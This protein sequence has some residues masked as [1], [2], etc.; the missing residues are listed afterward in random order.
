MC[1]VLYCRCCCIVRFWSLYM[2]WIFWTEHVALLYCIAITSYWKSHTVRSFLAHQS[3]DRYTKCTEHLYTLTLGNAA[4]LYRSGMSN[5]CDMCIIKK[6]KKLKL[7][8]CI[9]NLNRILK[10]IYNFLH[11][12]IYFSFFYSPVQNQSCWVTIKLYVVQVTTLY[13]SDR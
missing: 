5:I 4:V 6:L 12:D 10:Q 11:S 8:K 1:I 13:C 7:N 9:K 2:C 3:D